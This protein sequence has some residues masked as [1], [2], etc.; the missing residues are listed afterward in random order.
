M[1]G[2]F[3]AVTVSML[4]TCNS[5]KAHIEDTVYIPP[6]QWGEALDKLKDCKV[7]DVDLDITATPYGFYCND[8]MIYADSDKVSEISLIEIE[9]IKYLPE[10]VDGKL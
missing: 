9:G 5:A 10:K 7:V 3:F 4:L 6:K 8:W 1:K 2:F